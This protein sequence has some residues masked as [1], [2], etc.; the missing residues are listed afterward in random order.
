M[1]GSANG[2]LRHRERKQSNPVR[3][4]RLRIAVSW[5]ASP[6][7]VEANQL[8]AN[9]GELCFGQLGM[10]NASPLNRH[11]RGKLEPNIRGSIGALIEHDLTGRRYV[12]FRI[13]LKDQE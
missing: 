12:L 9:V 13:M 3:R 5:R 2:L 1:G 6:E 7:P 4:T 10:V 11:F 8:R